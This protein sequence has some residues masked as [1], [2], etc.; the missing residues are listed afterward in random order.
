VEN[1]NRKI[2]WKTIATKKFDHNVVLTSRLDFLTM[3]VMKEAYFK[4]SQDHNYLK[5]SL[6]DIKKKCFCVW[7]SLDDMIYGVCMKTKDENISYEPV[8]LKSFFD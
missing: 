5:I 6:D 2:E 8:K 1:I 7:D 4:Y 3:W